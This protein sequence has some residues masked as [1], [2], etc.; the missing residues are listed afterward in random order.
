MPIQQRSAISS[1][2]IG[3]S[4][5]GG[6]TGSKPVS[7]IFSIRKFE[8]E[9]PSSSSD[10][11]QSRSIISSRRGQGDSRISNALVPLSSGKSIGGFS[12]INSATRRLRGRT[13]GWRLAQDRFRA[14]NRSR[15]PAARPPRSHR[16]APAMYQDTRSACPPRIRS[17][18]GRFRPLARCRHRRRLPANPRWPERSAGRCGRPP[19]RR[20]TR[21]D[22]ALLPIRVWPSGG[23]PRDSSQ[24]A[25][26]I[27]QS[28]LP[29]ASCRLK[30]SQTA[31]MTAKFFV[32]KASIVNV[33]SYSGSLGKFCQSTFSW[34]IKRRRI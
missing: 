23:V 13:L 1:G 31:V 19:R 33:L 21:R 11:N 18:A 29:S 30:A 34:P 14:S 12:R 4:R 24:A 15:C 9:E 20:R 5:G 2:V 3:G 25:S 8:S 26:S 17:I 27:K 10:S 16:P 28:R 7:R 32:S 22:I 6:S